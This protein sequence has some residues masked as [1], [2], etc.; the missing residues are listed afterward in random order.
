MSRVSALA[1]LEAMAAMTAEPQTRFRHRHLSDRP[2]VVIPLTMAGEAGTPLAVLVGESSRSSTLLVVGQP[3][4]RDQRFAFAAEFG[5]IVMDY[6]DSVRQDR[7]DIPTRG[8]ER[9]SRY[10][11]APQV[12]VPNPGG[13][14][15][16]GDLGR[17]C[18]FRRTTGPYPVPAV[19]PE[20][21][22]WLTFLVET[23]EQAGTSMLLP[24]TD[25]LAEHWATGQ[26]ALEDQNLASL[27]AWIAP[28]AGLTVQEAM[29]DAENP[30]LC[31]PAGP[32]TSTEFDNTYLA[33]AMRRFDTARAAGN[34]QALAEAQTDLRGLLGEQLN[35]TWRLMWT[36][37]SLLRGVP[38][39]PRAATRFERDCDS[40]TDYSDYQDSGDARPQPKRDGA[41]RA[42]RRLSKLE[43]ALADFEA[44]MAFDDPYVRADRRSL[45]EAFAGTVVAAEPDRVVTSQANRRLLRPRVTVRTLD[46]VRL[47][48]DTTLISPT[49]PPGHKAE[50][51]STARDGE[52]SL[53]TVE[54]TGGMGR[55]RVPTPGTVPAVGQR[56]DYLPDPGWRPTPVFPEAGHVPWTH[57]GDPEDSESVDPVEAAQAA[58]EEWGDDT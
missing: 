4:N 33:P 56:V 34:E 49:M 27:M 6:I 21:G 26:S 57:A 36:A 47:A 16:L 3:R 7:R 51:F 53:I 46:P 2:L 1:H 5:R 58:T 14:K 18:R 41:I 17:M 9:R 44:D 11:S 38:E 39:A 20:V 42:A 35:P 43:R 24:I 30:A 22:K 10:T 52:A 13:I 40:F 29:S 54:V 28:P 8:K 12:L 15:A 45:G 37:V 31:P 23:A 48:D 19:V 32:A 25:L 55:G 50:I